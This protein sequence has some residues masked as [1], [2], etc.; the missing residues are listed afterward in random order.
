M[1]ST[2]LQGVVFDVDGVLFDTERVSRPIWLEVAQEMGRPQVGEIYQEFIGRNRTDILQ[3]IARRF[4]PDFPG[5]V[6][7]RRCSAATQA[8]IEEHGVPLKPGVRE[9]LS[10]LQQR[11]VPAALATSTGRERTERRLEM[12]GL[13]PFFQGIIT[14]DQV[15]H[16][17]P[18]PEIYLLACRCLGTD[19]TRTIA[20]EDSP[21]GIRSA[22]RA[23]MAVVMVPDLIAPTPEL[24]EMLTC[25]C[26]SL[27]ELRDRLASRF[28]PA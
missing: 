26:A 24:E 23:G 8:Y 14:G 11:G 15:V 10:F 28:S 21:N 12:T 7:M 16:S 5:E 2:E 18:D 22:H 27:L 6:Y 17:K 25:R 4:G 9:L 13:A 19:P 1:S 3:L 20:V